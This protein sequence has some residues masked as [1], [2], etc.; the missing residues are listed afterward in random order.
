MHWHIHIPQD[1]EAQS[2]AADELFRYEL[3]PP[4]MTLDLS[5]KFDFKSQWEK[6]HFSW[7]DFTSLNALQDHFISLNPFDKGISVFSVGLELGCDRI[8]W[9]LLSSSQTVANRSQICDD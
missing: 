4:R 6:L 3:I 8:L 1:E 5:Q 9:L 7:N 2:Q